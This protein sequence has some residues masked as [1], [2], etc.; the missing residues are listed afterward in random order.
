MVS[1]FH[2]TAVG[3]LTELHCYYCVKIEKLPLVEKFSKSSVLDFRSGSLLI[4]RDQD[5]TIRSHFDH[6]E[7]FL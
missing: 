5:T 1:G 4:L 2:V 7:I 3:L 6:L